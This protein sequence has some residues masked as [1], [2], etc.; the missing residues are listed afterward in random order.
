MMIHIMINAFWNLDYSVT[1]G[2]NNHDIEL[3]N[4]NKNNTNNPNYNE[5]DEMA[6]MLFVAHIDERFN[7][8]SIV[9]WSQSQK[10]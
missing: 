7:L 8:K 3:S 1:S 9:W 5:T 6:R 4:T 2:I 10:M